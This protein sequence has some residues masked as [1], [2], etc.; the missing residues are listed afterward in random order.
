MPVAIASTA[1]TPAES[2]A[3]CEDARKE[4]SVQEG[5]VRACKPN[6][7]CV[8]YEDCLYVNRAADLAAFERAREAE[9]RS[10]GPRVHRYCGTSEPKGR[11]SGGLCGEI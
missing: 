3:P 1:P 4:C 6:D 8:F 10:C 9:D 7:E 5:R 11:C 2:L